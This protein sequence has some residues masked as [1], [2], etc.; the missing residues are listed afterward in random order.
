MFIMGPVHTW[1]HDLGCSV[2]GTRNLPQGIHEGLIGFFFIR[3]YQEGESQRF[4]R[5][6]GALRSN[7]KIELHNISN[8]TVN[9]F[10]T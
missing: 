4:L 2:A 8:T 10:A 5:S 1:D 3:W 7:R 9:I 6:P